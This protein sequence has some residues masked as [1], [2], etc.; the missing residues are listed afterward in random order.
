[1]LQ[2]PLFAFLLPLCLASPTVQSQRNIT[3]IEN[4]YQGIYWKT[5]LVE[6]SDRQ[7]DILVESTR[8]MLELTKRT[9]KPMDTPGWQRFFVAD[10]AG[11]DGWASEKHRPDYLQVHNVMTQVNM[12]PRLGKVGKDKKKRE[13]QVTYR[14]PSG[15][16][17]RCHI[18]PE[19]ITFNNK[20]KYGWEISLCDD[21]FRLKYLNDITNGE[22]KS[23][24]SLPDLVSYEHSLAHEWAHVDLLGSSF[25]VMDITATNPNK[26]LKEKNVYGAEWSTVLAWYSGSP[27]SVGVKYNADNYAWFWTNNWFNEKWDWKDN[28]L[29]PR[30]G[31]DNSNAFDGPQYLS[32]PGSGFLMP[33]ETQPNEQKNCH[34]GNDPREV[35]C[36][37]L[38]EPYSEWLKDREKPFTSE[39]GCELTKQCWQSVSEYA[40][41]PACNCKCDGEK[42]PLSDPK[43]AGFRGGPPGSHPHA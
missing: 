17:S 18:N 14:C 2:I 33:N 42:L 37:Y 27:P 30:W 28:G 4:A 26:P 15:P 43:C 41:D 25:H 3:D 13:N 5:A 31:P 38:G 1:M 21:F 11:V 32:G 16:K 35:F 20:T 9:T 23:A 40:I 36:D 12:F 24:Q 19:Q 22:K 10:P 8:M 7:F 34:V 6:C 39:S 29:D